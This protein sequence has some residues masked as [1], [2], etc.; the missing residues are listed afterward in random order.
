[1]MQKP[2]QSGNMRIGLL[3][4]LTLIIVIVL[5]VLAVLE[6]STARAMSALTQ[7]Q[8]TMTSEAYQA[9][10]AGQTLLASIDAQLQQSRTEGRTR[11]AALNA[12]SPKLTGFS[13][14]ASTKDVTVVTRLNG[15]SVDATVTTADGRTL[16]ISVAIGEDLSYDV[17]S[18]RLA[19][20]AANEAEGP[21]LWTGASSN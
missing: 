8:S 5:S 7:R 17:T 19:A 18:W 1:M 15:T 11:D 6:I 16:S 9:E 2:S 13:S 20:V 14:V 21:S 10:V 12:L 4:I 3:T